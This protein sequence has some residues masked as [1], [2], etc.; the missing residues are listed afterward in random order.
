M[1][2]EMGIAYCGLACCLCTENMAEDTACV[3]CQNGGCVGKDGCV[4]YRCCREKGLDGCWQCEEFPCKGNMLDS[5]RIRAFAAFAR[6]Y[7]VEELINCLERN[8]QAGIQY[9][10][11]ESIKGDYDGCPEEDLFE[12][13]RT[14]KKTKQS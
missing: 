2:R 11:P 12:M 9:H 10:Y 14:G 7:G 8:E 3:G 4:N 5:P 1:K 6:N 13:I